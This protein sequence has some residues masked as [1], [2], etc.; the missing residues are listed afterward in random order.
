MIRQY[1][2]HKQRG[3]DSSRQLPSG[4]VPFLY[5]CEESVFRKVGGGRC[6]THRH[7]PNRISSLNRLYAINRLDT[8]VA[9]RIGLRR[10]GMAAQRSDSPAQDS[11][12][13]CGARW[14]DVVGVG[15]PIQERSFA[16]GFEILCRRVRSLAAILQAD[17]QPFIA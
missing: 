1:F 14:W 5:I 9:K 4:S 11:K 13:A 16:A 3:F 8:L 2:P 17:G 15:F 10:L 6:G 12:P 7:Q